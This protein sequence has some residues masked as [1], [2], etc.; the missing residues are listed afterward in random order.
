MFRDIRRSI[1][2]EMKSGHNEHVMSLLNLEDYGEGSPSTYSA[3]KKFWSYIRSRKRDNVGI[4]SFTE[5]GR[6][7]TEA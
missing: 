1:K 7:I 5:E 3:G 2:C 4:P 6:E